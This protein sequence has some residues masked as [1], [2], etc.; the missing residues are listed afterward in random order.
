MTMPVVPPTWRGGLER[1]IYICPRLLR[2]RQAWWLSQARTPYIDMTPHAS[3]ASVVRTR[4]AA[5]VVYMLHRCLAGC[6][7]RSSKGPMPCS[8]ARAAHGE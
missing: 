2:D 4:G 7:R 1:A 3:S 5:R 8:V 6:S